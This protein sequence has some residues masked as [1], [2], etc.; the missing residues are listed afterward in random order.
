[1]LVANLSPIANNRIKFSHHDSWQAPE[2][3]GC[4]VLANFGGEILYIGKAANIHE[5]INQHL[6][7]GTKKA[8]TPF[9]VAFWFYYRL[10]NKN[11]LNALETGWCNDHKMNEKGE[12][13]FFN[14]INP[15][16]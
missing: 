2:N 10:C 6:S 1:M 11:D 14:K 7:E 16:A 9:G 5:R 15:P 13:P 8:K 12:L 3:P 4:Y